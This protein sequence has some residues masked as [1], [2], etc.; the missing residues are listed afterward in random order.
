LTNTSGKQFKET[1]KWPEFVVNAKVLVGG[2]P[3]LTLD[4]EK[5]AAALVACATVPAMTIV[6]RKN[7]A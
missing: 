7:T 4:Q 5:T 1:T 2:D 6:G 3:D